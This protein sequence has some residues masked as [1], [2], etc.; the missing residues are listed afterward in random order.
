MSATTYP[1]LKDISFSELN[2][3][4]NFHLRSDTAILASQCKLHNPI[5]LEIPRSRNEI[6]YTKM[7]SS[8]QQPQRKEN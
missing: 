4:I 7:F 5:I 3:I 8:K 6:A 2:N 1:L